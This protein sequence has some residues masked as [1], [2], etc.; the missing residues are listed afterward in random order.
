M[1]RRC[2]FIWSQ[3]SPPCSGATGKR[4]QMSQ[5]KALAEATEARGFTS[6]H[7]LTPNRK[8]RAFVPQIAVRCTKGARGTTDKCIAHGGG[9]R[10]VEPGCTKGAIGT[11]DKC[12]AHGGGARC[13]EPGCTK[14]AQGTTDK[15]KAHGGIDAGVEGKLSA[16]PMTKVVATSGWRASPGTNLAIQVTEK[17]DEKEDAPKTKKPKKEKKE[18]TFTGLAEP[19]TTSTTPHPEPP[20]LRQSVQPK[21]ARVFGLTSKM[22]QFELGPF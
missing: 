3:V 2:L 7:W 8:V 22:A 15:C 1:M 21:K 14:S 5:I 19:T 17:V 4:I 13:V 11:T 20:P 18:P 6:Q 16:T 12:K 10:C 9:A